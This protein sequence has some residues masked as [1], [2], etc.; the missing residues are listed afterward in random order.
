MAQADTGVTK[1]AV[2]QIPPSE[3]S[4]TCL[5]LWNDGFQVMSKPFN[6][7]V[8]PLISLALST[9]FALFLII[10]LR[11]ATVSFGQYGLIEPYKPGKPIFVFLEF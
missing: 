1:G 11:Y 3:S 10:V 8:V 6:L 2:P 4:S 9:L 5:K 7:A